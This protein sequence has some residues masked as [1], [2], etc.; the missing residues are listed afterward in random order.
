MAIET[1]N[2]KYQLVDTIS[3]E[4]KE[5]INLLPDKN[6]SVTLKLIKNK[7]FVA[8]KEIPT[9]II[10][11][12]GPALLDNAEKI[13]NF[14]EKMTYDELVSTFETNKDNLGEEVSKDEKSAISVLIKS[15]KK[16]VF[17]DDKKK[18]LFGNKLIRILDFYCEYIGDD[19]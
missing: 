8:L 15:T 13:Y 5:L 12:I 7:I 9:V 18:K 10:D 17:N 19:N 1:K 3:K 4:I 14:E 2:N 11:I 16:K 6:F